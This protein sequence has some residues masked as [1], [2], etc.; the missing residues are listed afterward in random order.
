MNNS[1]SKKQLT[2]MTQINTSLLALNKQ[3]K[4]SLDDWT[5][6][7]E[8]EVNEYQKLRIQ[9]LQMEVE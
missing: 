6:I 8:S 5:P 9:E 3:L 2:E 7:E 1:S 4:L